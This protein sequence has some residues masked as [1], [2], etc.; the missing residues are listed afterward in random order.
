MSTN[1]Y[2]IAVLLPTHKRTDTLTRSV[3][4]IIEN[5]DHPENLQIIFGVDNNDPI[6]QTH[7]NN[8]ICPYLD[9]L[10]VDYSVVEFE[11]MGYLGLNRYY[12]GTAPEADADWL[13][14]WNDDAFITSK[15]WDTEVRKHNG[16]FKLLKIHTHHEHPYSI[17]PICPKEWF[18]LFG[19]MS[20]HQM[21]DAELSQNAYMLDLIQIIDVHATHDRADLTGNNNDTTQ[22]NKITLEGN[23]SDPRDFHHSNYHNSRLRDCETL[24]KYL[25]SKGIDMSFWEDVK[26]GKQDPFKKMKENDPN[27][28][29]TSQR[30]EG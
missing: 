5:A 26:A 9:G 27:G 22:N 3:K 14:V 29:I 6:G 7:I 11:P 19:F 18:E 13:F 2:S 16:E 1:T 17:F 25:V 23:P 28:Q 4:S 20:R 15:G 8:V 30:I 12:N 21:V 10:G 24:S